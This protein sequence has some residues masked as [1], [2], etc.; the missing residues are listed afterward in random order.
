[1]NWTS[2]AH[3]RSQVQRL[4]DKGD[5]LRDV[6]SSSVR[7]PLRLSVSAPAAS[8]LANH[9]EAVRAWV[10][11]IAAVPHV[12]IEWR[13]WNHRVQGGQ[14]LP[15]A[16]WIDSRDDALAAIGKQQ[17]AGLFD[18]LW[19]RTAARQ[20]ALLAWLSRRPLQAL[21]MADRWE[22]LMSVVTWMQAH[23]RPGTY[24][25]QVDAA[26]V[27][28]KFLE[29]HCGV[30]IELLDLALPQESIDAA[31]TGVGQF[32]RRYGF[33]DKPVRV[34]FRILDA[35]RAGLGTCGLPADVT[36]DADSFAALAYPVR[37]VF[38]TENE[39]NFLAFPLWAGAIVIFGAGYGWE[40][41]AR[42]DWLHRCGLHYWGDIDTHGFAIL[43]Q[44]RIHFPRAASF[45]MDR[46]T[47]LAHEAQWG[48]EP[49]PVRR[50]L[51][52][53][54]SEEAAL[55]EDLRTDRLR[56]RL[57]LEQERIGFGWLR[58]RLNNLQAAVA[59]S[60]PPATGQPAAE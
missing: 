19:Q 22:R 29:A 10:Q 3:L 37:Q 52:R 36:L 7:W 1:M 8:D 12:R 38:I 18:A 43:D 13:D 11:A 5:L 57:R 24:L 34:R 27:D 59:Q 20:P 28:S 25:R 41:L 15:A 33:R 9:F 16:I 54:T 42:A 30:L 21:E 49:E 48:E 60:S 47:L 40:N 56:P 31:A 46:D 2:E 44:L 32:A 6:V 53:L 17:A 50:D 51:G 45:L 39:I 14:R 35:E 26:G 4:W 23:P 55:F 58:V